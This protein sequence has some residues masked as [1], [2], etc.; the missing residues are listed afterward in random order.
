MLHMPKLDT[1]DLQGSGSRLLL[2]GPFAAGDIPSTQPISKH[3]QLDVGVN[4]SST[5]LPWLSDYAPSGVVPA[6]AVLAKF[7]RRVHEVLM[8][9]NEV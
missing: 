9:F 6:D 8:K 1:L 4:D 2:S 5:E 3:Q 7:E